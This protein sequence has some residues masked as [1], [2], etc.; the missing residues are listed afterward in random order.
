MRAYLRIFLILFLACI[1]IAGTA[2]ASAATILIVAGTD[3]Y[4]HTAAIKLSADLSGSNTVT[5]V[6]TGVPVSL[7]GYTAIYDVRYLAA[8]AFTAGEQTQYL[9][10]LN[11]APGNT[12]FLMGENQ[13]FGARNL[14]VSA[15]IAL[16][17]GGTIAAPVGSSANAE[18]LDPLFAITPNAISTVKFQQCGVV[19]SSGTGKFGAKEANGTSGCVLYFRP[20]KLANAPGGALVVVYDVDFIAGA[21]AQGS[22]GNEV[23]FRQNMEEFVATGGGGKPQLLVVAGTSALAQQAAS[24]LSTDLSSQYQVTTVNSGVPGSLANYAQIYDLRYDDSPALSAAEES[25]YAAYLNAASGNSLFVLGEGSGASDAHNQAISGLIT[26]AGGGAIVPPASDDSTSETLKVPFNTTPNVISSVQFTACGLATSSGSGSFGS[27]VADGSAG[28]SLYFPRGTL[29]NALGG[30]MTVVYNSGFLTSAPNQGALNEVSFRANIENTVSQGGT[31]AGPVVPTVVLTSSSNPS[32]PVSPVIFTARTSSTPAAT[33]SVTFYEGSTLLGTEPLSSGVANFTRSTLST[34]VHSIVARYGGDANFAA[35]LSSEI[36]QTISQTTP[37][38]SFFLPS[39]IVYGTSLSNLLIASATSASTIVPGTFVFTAIPTGGVVTSATVFPAGSYDVTANFTPTDTSTYTTATGSASIT[40]SK[41]T[42]TITW[43]TPSP[44]AYGTALGAA[45]LNASSGGVAGTFVYSPGT[46]TL[47]GAG[48]STLATAFTPTDSADYDP[49]SA[50]VSLTVTKVSPGVTWATPSPIVYGTALTA[51]QLNANSG[52]VAGTFVYSPAVGT[53][54][55]TGTQVLTV[56]FTPTSSTNYLPTTRTVSLTVNPASVVAT[57]TA[58]PNPSTLQGAVTFQ[59]TF[60]SP[61][62][63]PTGTVSFK[64]GNTVLGSATLSAGKASF[65]TSALTVGTHTIT[66]VYSGDSN[67]V[68]IASAALSEM[69]V[70]FGVAP[71]A[72]SGATNGPTQSIPPGGTAAYD[73]SIVPTAGTTFPAPII[74]NV[75]GL[76]PGATATVAPST[77]VQQSPTIWTFPANMP[78]A[79]V[80]LSIKLPSQTARVGAMPGAFETLKPV[81]LGFLLLPFVGVL[82]RSRDRLGSRRGGRTLLLLLVLSGGSA[83]LAGLNGCGSNNGF[84]GQPPQ[85]YSVVV[86]ASTGSLSRS[87]TIILTVQ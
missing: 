59:S 78:L 28:C 34:G 57:L 64:D 87:T 9:G 30:S 82:R 22:P 21:A 79:N 23:S 52:G 65:A 63:A 77:W 29:G 17:G 4:A 32:P 27:T 43:A 69:V 2:T 53:I 36:S 48:V 26:L 80:T 40:V 58:S 1:M 41:A 66:A 7:A 12:I 45:Q 42:P 50:T 11:A 31:L 61:V 47:P 8:P 14:P 81:W 71:G 49:A 25:Q 35:A 55:T 70:D 83:L 67:F 5:I 54:L 39:T 24:T 38:V 16:A 86:T 76:P 85:T 6:Q 74:L 51:L 46:G 72:G 20:G 13:S 19:T 68:G 62:G 84:F 15:F 18:T 60:V 37:S 44:I 33:G 10:F 56:T 3:S 73:L 75:A